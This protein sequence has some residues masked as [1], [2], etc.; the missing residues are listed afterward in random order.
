MPRKKFDNFQ[1]SLTIP[2]SDDAV[3]G[4]VHQCHRLG[5]PGLESN[6]RA[7]EDVEPLTVRAAAVEEKLPVGLHEMVVRP[8]LRART[9]SDN[10]NENKA[11]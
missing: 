6:G 2:A 5:V 4:D 7:R 10:R 11:K 1:R 9:T 3:T 8:D